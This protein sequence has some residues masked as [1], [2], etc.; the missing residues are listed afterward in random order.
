MHSRCCESELTP[1]FVAQSLE[2][3]VES[4]TKKDQLVPLSV[5]AHELRIRYSIALDRLLTG[6]LEGERKGGRWF[7]YR[8]ALDRELGGVDD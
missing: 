3:G 5:A 1:F 2:D 7:V 8:S 6:A 4:K